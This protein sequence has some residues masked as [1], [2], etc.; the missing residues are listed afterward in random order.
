[1]RAL[2]ALQLLVLAIG[3]LQFAFVPSSITNPLLAVATLAGFACVVVLAHVLPVIRAR[4]VLQQCADLLL[5]TAAITLLAISSGSIHSS[6]TALYTLPLAG[7]AIVFARWWAVVAFAGL[8]AALGFLLGSLTAQIDLR[9]TEFG[10]LLVSVFTPGAVVALLLATLVEKMQHADRRIRDLASTDTLTGLLNFRAFENVLQQEH[11]KAERFGRTYSLVMVDVDNLTHI[12]E[13]LG[14]EA[15]NLIINAVA[16]AI[17]RS[18]RASDIAARLGGDEFV[19]LCIECNT[20][21]ATAVAQRIRNMVYAGTVS[22]ANRLIRANVSVGIA[23]FPAD[24][25]YPK[26][27]MILASQR[28]QQDLDLRRGADAQ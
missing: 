2:I 26:E 8:I 1:M 18:V 10:V 16:A 13:T 28:M 19:V 25:L 20:E 5:M 24:H 21:T 23:N 17:T 27:L 22:V 14:H 9:S 12:N 15:G 6:L 3:V 7:A 11:R 4:R